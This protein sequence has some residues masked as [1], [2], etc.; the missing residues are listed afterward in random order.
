LTVCVRDHVDVVVVGAGFAGLT[1]ARQLTRAGLDVL[2]LEGRDR[3]GG[4]TAPGS[5]AGVPVDLG[6]A[7]VGPTQDAVQGLAAEL[8]CLTTPT[9][10]T[11]S[12][13]IKWRGRVRSYSGTVPS[14]SLLGL[15][16]IARI[17]W[18]FAR[19]ARTV[20]VAQPWSA[21]RAEALDDRT[22]GDW[23]HALRA[24]ATTRDLLA[25]MSR[26][27]WGGEPDEVSLLH[28]LT[29]VAAAGGL[30]RMLDVR[31]GAQQ[32][33][34]VAG[35]HG[36]AARMAD[37]LGARVVLSAAVEAVEH[38][39][40]GVTVVSTAGTVSARAV[41]LAVPPQHR[42]A[43][44][45][46]PA[47]PAGPD[48]VAGAWPQGTLSKAFAAYNTPFWRAE[49]RSGQALSDTGPVFITFDVSPA[50][51]PGVLLG[52][53]DARG[54]DDL[55]PE[56][57]RARAVD[58]FADLFGDRARHPIDYLDFSWGSEPFCPG[59]PTAVVPPGSWTTVGRYLRTPVGC[60]FW[61]GTETADRWTGFLDGA[62]RSGQR[63]ATEVL[64]ALR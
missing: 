51:G 14:L 13:L 44:T 33:H 28:A 41:I 3:V 35:T 16:D 42:G 61:A 21:P 25:I 24:T 36:I 62:V 53:V 39:A 5:V 54:F 46:S 18:Q 38:D 45:F 52:F 40:S 63:A 32:D 56:Q 2:V 30:D 7:F 58:C 55:A 12:N 59:G 48:R 19:L 37:E 27:T 29:Y 43:V 23:L 1:A 8:D 64:A 50:D 26:V 34:L 10:D 17:R 31:N 15:I 60:I 20:P 11:G 4:R 22:L 47:L 9:Y 6:A 49:G 57:R